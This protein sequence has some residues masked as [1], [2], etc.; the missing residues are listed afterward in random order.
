MSPELSVRVT[1]AVRHLHVTCVTM[2]QLSESDAPL[3]A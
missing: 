1:S 3:S 2:Y